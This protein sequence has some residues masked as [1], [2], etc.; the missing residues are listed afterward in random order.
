MGCP[1]EV[2]DIS[3]YTFN[4][5]I[6]G[7]MRTIRA[8]GISEKT[9]AYGPVSVEPA[10]DLFPQYTA[11]KLDR[12]TGD[13]VDLLIGLDYNEFLA[14]GGQG[15][16][17][18]DSLQVMDTPLSASGKVLTGHHP[19]I[20]ARGSK[21]SASAVNFRKAV[22][23][24]SQDFSSSGTRAVNLVRCLAYTAEMVETDP[25]ILEMEALPEGD[26]LALEQIGVIIPRTCGK[27]KECLQCVI[28]EDGPS[29]KEHLELQIMR[30]VMVHDPVNKQMHVS[31]PV[32]GNPSGYVVNYTQALSRA[33][34]L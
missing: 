2:Q 1:E 27:C 34:S 30:D 8:L 18:V 21:F 20:R 12:P 23:L 29:V 6:D 10:Y 14:S 22:I 32:V 24:D 3:L 15:D 9:D 19:S 16:D 11:P 28:Q 13:K 17:Q 7:R 31:Y 33:K 26:F 5:R 25:D 4:W